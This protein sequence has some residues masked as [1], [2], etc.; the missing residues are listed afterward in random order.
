MLQ[1]MLTYQ[2]IHDE[3][4]RTCL[5]V[6]PTIVW[7]SYM[8]VLGFSSALDIYIYEKRSM[9]TPTC[10]IAGR[11]GP[12]A[13][14]VMVVI[15]VGRLA[16]GAFRSYSSLFLKSGGRNIRGQQ[17]D[18]HRDEHTTCL[19]YTEGWK[20]KA[21]YFS[22]WSWCELDFYSLLLRGTIVNRTEYCK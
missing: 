20:V 7:Y 18:R 3:Y 19:Y 12:T 16:S 11:G 13:Q 4:V 6:S 21:N 14:E 22:S 10:K 17:S 8:Y 5:M 1:Q 9:H 2:H 15:S